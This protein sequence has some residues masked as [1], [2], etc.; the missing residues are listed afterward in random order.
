MTPELAGAGAPRRRRDLSSKA[1]HAT[2]ARGAKAE[3]TR[4]SR[5]P[6]PPGGRR[7]GA[8]RSPGA[9]R[10]GVRQRSRR[11]ATDGGRKQSEKPG[12]EGLGWG[13]GDASRDR[14]VSGPRKVSFRGR[15]RAGL[16]E[17]GA[18][19]HSGPLTC[20]VVVQR[21][22]FLRQ[23]ELHFIEEPVVGGPQAPDPGG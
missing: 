3:R 22:Q 18:V 16:G 15:R 2:R 21:P 17:W 11:L 13:V 14:V 23:H 7:N 4:A 20:R 1:S 5:R 8:G 19:S 6:A 12:G 10:N 9:P